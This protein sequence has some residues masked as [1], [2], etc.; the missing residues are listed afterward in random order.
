[1]AR[2]GHRERR[3]HQPLNAMT[4]PRRPRALYFGTPEFAATILARLL[5]PDS[6]VEVVGAVTQPDK[7][8]GRKQVLTPPPVKALALD[9]GIPVVQPLTLRR[10]AVVAALQRFRP[11]IGIVAAYGK[12]LPA[13][14][15]GLPQLGHLNVH[16]S[17]LPRW[18]GA[19]PIGAAILAGDAETGVTIMQLDEGMDT[20]P[21]L[22]A[23]AEPIRPD[24]TTATLE[25]RLAA[26]GADLLA[27]VLPRYIAGALELQPQ[28]DAAATYCHPVRKADG[29]IDWTEPAVQIERRVRAMQPW[30]VAH[31]SWN[32]KQLLVLRA[33]VG[34]ADEADT[35]AAAGT[36]VPSG[37]GAAVTT[38]EGLLVLEEVQLEGRSPTPIRAF[39]NGYRA[40]VGSRLEANQA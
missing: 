1:M 7:P 36:V 17:L 11:E 40:F 15:L 4:E 3:K 34:V 28:D 37:K 31:T 29:L 30:P 32:G 38:G 10:P 33:R 9:H 19:W 21:T 18:R 20:G 14:V 8:V 2:A 16:A 39:V 24:D 13:D 23:R 27:E 6:P 26:L 5:G 25:Q 35:P 12:I 22:A